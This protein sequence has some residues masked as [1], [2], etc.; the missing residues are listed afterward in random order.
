MN[1]PSVGEL[2]HLVFPASD[3]PLDR[4]AGEIVEGFGRGSS[5]ERRMEERHG[6]DS[7]PDDGGSGDR[8]GLFDFR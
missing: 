3:D 2:Y 6:L 4:R 1:R 5:L 8:G 7:L